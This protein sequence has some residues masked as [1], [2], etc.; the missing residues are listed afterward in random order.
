MFTKE[1]KNLTVLLLKSIKWNIG[2]LSLL[3]TLKS[4]SF[5][6]PKIPDIILTWAGFIIIK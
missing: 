1:T 5:C 2:E 4:L 3:F 6:H